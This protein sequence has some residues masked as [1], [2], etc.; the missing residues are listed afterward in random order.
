MLKPDNAGGHGSNPDGF[1][2]NQGRTRSRN[3][4]SVFFS[5]N[6]TV[7]ADAADG[8][9]TPDPSDQA[10]NHSGQGQNITFG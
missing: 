4:A 6:G 10:Q 5:W 9:P 8:P 3:T 7:L 1:M 2:V